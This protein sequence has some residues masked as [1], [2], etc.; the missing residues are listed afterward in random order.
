VQ[1]KII[2]T[3]HD[4]IL[5][6]TK[7]RVTNGALEGMNNKVKAISRR[8]FG[9]RATWTYIASIYQCCAAPPLP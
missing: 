5:A 4:G 3:H 8:V 1:V 6:R 9:F 7:L 2:R